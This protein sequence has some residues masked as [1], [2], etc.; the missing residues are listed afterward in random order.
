M[1]ESVSYQRI[2][3]EG[4]VEGR[5]EGERDLLVRVATRRFSAPGP[6]VLARL[7]A[8]TDAA[9]LGRLADRVLDV[10]GWDELLDG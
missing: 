2:L 9:E 8:V 7:A 4:R 6:A 5:V 3:S 1:R 10:A